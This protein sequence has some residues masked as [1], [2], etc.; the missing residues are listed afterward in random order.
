MS[1]LYESIPPERLEQ[2]LQN[3]EKA[4]EQAAQPVVNPA[5]EALGGAVVRGAEVL[6]KEDGRGNEVADGAQEFLSSQI[7]VGDQA[8]SFL[9]D[10]ERE[11]KKQV[12]EITSEP[13]LESDPVAKLIAAND[14]GLNDF[15]TQRRE[16]SGS[17]A[18][19]D[20]SGGGFGSWVRANTAGLQNDLWKVMSDQEKADPNNPTA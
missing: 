10:Q 5:I 4:V 3:A 8:S 7:P 13:T 6:T 18:R 19:G 14:T 12:D 16:Y 9:E 20:L 11:F 1:Q 2:Y 15:I 17:R